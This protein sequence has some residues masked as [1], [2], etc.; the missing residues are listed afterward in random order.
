MTQN[1]NFIRKIAY[2][3]AIVLLLFPLFLLGQPAT[4]SSSGDDGAG[5][6]GIKRGHAGPDALQLRTVAGRIG[7]DRSGQ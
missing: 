3:C 4:R 1:A 7:Q 6:P 5:R 2:G